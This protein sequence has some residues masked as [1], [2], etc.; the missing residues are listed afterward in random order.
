MVQVHPHELGRD[1]AELLF[2]RVDG[3]ASDSPTLIRLPS[4]L[5]I[6][7]SSL[8][9]GRQPG[10]SRPELSRCALDT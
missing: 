8:A 6:G 4:K 2:R 5:V 9:G 7:E 10:R 1:G 3:D